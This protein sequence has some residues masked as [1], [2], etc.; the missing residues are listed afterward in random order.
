MEQMGVH[1]VIG[2]HWHPID[3]DSDTLDQRGAHHRRIKKYFGAV[4]QGT[5]GVI[6]SSNFIPH[7]GSIVS[8]VGKNREQRNS[9]G[10]GKKLDELS[11]VTGHHKAP[12]C[13]GVDGRLG[14]GPAN[15]LVIVFMPEPSSLDCSRPGLP[16]KLKPDMG[17]EIF[18]TPV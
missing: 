9:H 14:G 13:V 3:A 4:T 1:V 12:L 11:L 6:A 10:V 5:G 16:A 18:L 17:L 8:G 7:S 15:F 2:L